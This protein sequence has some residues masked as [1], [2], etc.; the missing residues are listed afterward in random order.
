LV[1][2][3]GD[4]RAMHWCADRSLGVA[5]TLISG[6]STVA[7]TFNHTIV[8]AKDMAVAD[9]RL[10]GSVMSIF[11]TEVPG[12]LRGRGYGHQFVRGT[13]DEVRRLNFKVVPT[14]CFVRQVIDRSPEF[15]DLLA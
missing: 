7:I 6:A 10:A 9:Y 5:G 12:P 2:T 4:H 1:G 8:P 13:L 15:Q 14:C 11:H 3:Q